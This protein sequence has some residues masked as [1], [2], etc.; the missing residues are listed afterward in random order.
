M[1]HLHLAAIAAAMCI[2]ACGGGGGGYTSPTTPVVTPS[3]SVTVALS[4]TAA[5]GLMANADVNVYAANADGTVS[6]T[7]LASTTTQADGTYT[8]SFSG[9][10]GKAYVI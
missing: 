9:E 5:K 7:S 2:S 6:T 3:T 1:R 8:L 4:G 10:Q